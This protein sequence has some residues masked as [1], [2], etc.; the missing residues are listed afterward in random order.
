MKGKFGQIVA[1]FHVSNGLRDGRFYLQAEDVARM[2]SMSVLSL[3]EFEML[4]IK[5]KMSAADRSVLRRS[6]AKY[7]LR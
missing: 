1:L 6:E 2:S 3:L 5:D 4:S 7:W